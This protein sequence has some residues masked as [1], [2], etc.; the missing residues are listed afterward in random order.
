MFYSLLN[1]LEPQLFFLHQSKKHTSLADGSIS[2]KEKLVDTLYVHFVILL[3]ACCIYAKVKSSLLHYTFC[4]VCLLKYMY[5]YALFND[6]YCTLCTLYYLGL[7]VLFYCADQVII[8]IIV[9][10][11]LYCTYIV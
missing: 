8:C 11:V 10:H 2:S 1:S 9:L 4:T 3:K 7:Y 6:M 5:C